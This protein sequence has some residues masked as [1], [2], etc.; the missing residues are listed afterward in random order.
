MKPTDI[1]E[2]I[3]RTL[4]LL[5]SLGTAYSMY[6]G[7][8][9]LILGG[10]QSS[11]IILIMIPPFIAGMWLLL[12]ARS[13]VGFCYSDREKANRTTMGDMVPHRKVEPFE[14]P[15]CNHI[16]NVITTEGC[17]THCGHQVE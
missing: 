12:F 4:G 5:I 13:L 16:S 11:A 10:A 1:F 14:C 6:M 9:G 17:C 8:V 7:L 15:R 3:V 2:I